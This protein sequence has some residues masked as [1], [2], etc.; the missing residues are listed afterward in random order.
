M[1]STIGREGIQFNS[2]VKFRILFIADLSLV[3]FDPCRSLPEMHD[4]ILLRYCSTGRDCSMHRQSATGQCRERPR[5]VL[6]A[7]KCKSEVFGG[8]AR[9]GRGRGW[10]SVTVVCATSVELETGSANLLL[11]NRRIVRT[12][13]YTDHC[14]PCRT[15]PLHPVP[16]PHCE[17]TQITV[18]VPRHLRWYV[19]SSQRLQYSIA[20]TQFRHSN[21]LEPA[22]SAP[23]LANSSAPPSLLRSFVLV[24]CRPIWSDILLS[25]RAGTG[26]SL[27]G[28]A[29]RERLLPCTPWLVG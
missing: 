7:V 27:Q 6:R 1:Y 11:R 10:F 5:S 15:A 3:G 29:E 19:A 16:R 21:I 17:T 13:P 20:N 25:S 9:R 4:P 24:T 2:R 18:L 8:G 22:P 28:A 26:S 23:R 14:A 12:E